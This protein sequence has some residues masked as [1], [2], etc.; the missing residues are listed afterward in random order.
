MK[1]FLILLFALLY[2]SDAIGQQT[3]TRFIRWAHNGNAEGFIIH[4][5]PQ[6][7]DTIE[8][9]I[10]PKDDPGL[11]TTGNLYG[12]FVEY[13]GVV[14]VA[15]SAYDEFGQWSDPS[16]TWYFGIETDP[17]EIQRINYCQRADLNNDGVVGGP[18]YSLFAGNWGKRCVVN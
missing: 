10:I 18:D 3:N 16:R 1:F 11:S 5:K 8:E 13:V 2:P 17:T 4:I 15:V 6:A 9:I 12:F 14:Y 7:S